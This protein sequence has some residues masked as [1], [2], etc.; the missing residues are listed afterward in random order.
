MKGYEQLEDVDEIVRII[1]MPVELGGDHFRLLELYARKIA[2]V[3][4]EHFEEARKLDGEI[5]SVRR[6]M[7]DSGRAQGV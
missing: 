4:A 5:G 2:E 3:R 1:G 7:A 6:R